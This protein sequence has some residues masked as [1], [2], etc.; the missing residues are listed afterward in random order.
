MTEPL[1]LEP[2]FKYRIWGG[3]Q[4]D[5]RFHYAGVPDGPV[6]EC[7]G[8]SAHPNGP[9]TVRSGPHAG[10]TLPEVWESDPG[11]FG[12]TAGE[13]AGTTFPLLVKLLDAKEWLSVQ[14]HP[15]DAE[16]AELEGVP[17]GKTECWYVVTA[18]P[19]AELIIGHRARDA[20]ELADMIDAGKW[21]ELLLRRTVVPGDFV[22]V[23]TGTVHAIGPGIL[24]C[25]VQQNCDTT[26]R[27]YDFDRPD[28]D[29]NLR[30]LHLDKAKRVLR[31]P[32]D[33]ATTDTAGPVEDVPGGARRTLVR[34][35]F[36]EAT[37]H[38]VV[39]DGYTVSFPAYEL[40]T[41]TDGAGSMTVGGAAYP[42]AA[43]DHFIVP[44]GGGAVTFS[45]TLTLVSSH[46]AG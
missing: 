3:R 29:G 11:F 18:E 13:T 4:F 33:P 27:V 44:A 2:V 16:A 34:G 19:G 17:R 14:A 31:A 32:Y 35:E 10:R 23:P 6:G 8:I 38:E 43:G 21:D 5:T 9:S 41:V 24:V 42:L 12:L 28:A 39:G 1:F 7:W 20:E 30:E 45:G 37:Q 22:Y 40:A 26:Y 25:E 15:D 36:F 46:P